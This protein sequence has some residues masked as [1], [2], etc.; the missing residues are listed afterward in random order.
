MGNFR[1]KLA[2]E[3]FSVRAAWAERN[4]RPVQSSD[5]SSCS[6]FG[7]PCPE[8][9]LRTTIQALGPS[10][11]SIQTIIYSL[12]RNKVNFENLGAVLQLCFKIS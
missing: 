6:V 5:Y 7:G 11:Y 8:L 10:Y 9:G 4:V 3:L 1:S 2:V 12:I